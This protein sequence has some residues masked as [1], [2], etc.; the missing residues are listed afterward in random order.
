MKK[1]EQLAAA[2][3]QLRDG[4]NPRM[5]IRSYYTFV[6]KAA[7]T[8]SQAAGI[9]LKADRIHAWLVEQGYLEKKDGILTPTEEGR[10]EGLLLVRRSNHDGPYMA[11]VLRYEGVAFVLH[12][13]RQILCRMD[14]NYRLLLLREEKLDTVIDLLQRVNITF[15]DTPYG[16]Q[17][18]IN[19]DLS[20]FHDL[21]HRIGVDENGYENKKSWPED[22]TI[23]QMSLTQIRSYLFILARAQRFGDFV[24]EGNLMNGTYLAIVQR[25]KVLKEKLDQ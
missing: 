2:F 23:G 25:L 19:V 14:D 5:Y 6:I 4:E 13:I 12:Q 15:A 9:E 16:K 3:S 20:P 24:F 8:I 18:R 1:S 10:E 22:L 11:L 21:M 7:T 17:S